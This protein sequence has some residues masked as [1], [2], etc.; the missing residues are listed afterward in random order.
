MADDVVMLSEQFVLFE[1]ADADEIG[2]HV[3]DVTV[4]IRGGEDIGGVAD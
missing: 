3:G 4:E 2:I 1:S